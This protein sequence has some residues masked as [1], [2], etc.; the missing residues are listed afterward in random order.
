MAALVVLAV[1]GVLALL[2]STGGYLGTDTGAKVITLDRMAEEGTF[3]P[4]IGYWAEEW[5]PDGDYHPLFDTRRSDGGEW[6]NVTTLPMLIAAR[7]LYAARRVPA[8]P[9]APDAWWGACRIR[10][11]GHRSQRGR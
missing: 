7:P 4:A 8:R 3:S 9:G 2:N 5:D 6:V 11:P 1:Y 10:V